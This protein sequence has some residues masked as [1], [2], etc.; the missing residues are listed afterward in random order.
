MTEEEQ[1]KQ[2][3]LQAEIKLE[4]QRRETRVIAA[5]VFR[6]KAMFPI[7]LGAGLESQNFNDIV[8]RDAFPEI[9]KAGDEESDDAR[10]TRQNI[11]ARNCDDPK[12]TFSG[13]VDSVPE[14]IDV[15]DV[16]FLKFADM[17]GN[18]QEHIIRIMQ[19]PSLAVGLRVDALQQEM[20]SL[21]TDYRAVASL[22][23]ELASNEEENLA[24]LYSTPEKLTHV[25]GL[26]DRIMNVTLESA[27][28][29]NRAIALAGAL[30]VLSHLAGRNYTDSRG[31]YPNLYIILVAPSTF[32]KQ[33][34][35]SV[36]MAIGH[37]LQIARSFYEQPAS[38][39]ATEDAI[40]ESPSAIFQID[41]ISN[42]LHIMNDKRQGGG[43]AFYNYLLQIFSASETVH[44][45]RARAKSSYGK[46]ESAPVAVNPSL[47][48][49]GCATPTL[50]YEEIT[51]K[52]ILSGLLNR[53]VIIETRL[54]P[55]RNEDRKAAVTIPP[56]LVDDLHKTIELNPDFFDREMP[57][58]RL[59]QDG[60]G[61]KE[62]FKE[63]AKQMDAL[64]D[65]LSRKGDDSGMAIWGRAIE[66]TGKLALLYAISQDP[67]EPVVT[68]EGVNWAWELCQSIIARVIAQSKKFM[69]V[70]EKEKKLLRVYQY[71]KEHNVPTGLKRGTVSKGSHISDIK[72]MDNIEAMLVERGLILVKQGLRQGAK[73]Y[74]LNVKA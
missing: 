65:K 69:N 52:T 5:M 36:N 12:R 25:P 34:P 41:E 44:R 60:P 53:C 47:T 1:K 43:D 49:F 59:A 71:I 8:F 55:K 23:G 3:Q 24:D 61:V 46:S 58:R 33:K 63:L 31:T 9:L 19:D 16:A 29:P 57:Q 26:I 74:F 48:I 27:V 66:Q 38:G 45:A 14:K 15:E 54:L 2:E 68:L 22:L 39:Q 73:L 40:I 7:V 6:P 30:A 51:E 64:I 13:L 42:L 17:F 56:E 4:R 62:R 50:F 18:Y 67:K 32:G 72:E 20:D 21:R 28:H 35:R 37:K 70:D 10:E 11:L